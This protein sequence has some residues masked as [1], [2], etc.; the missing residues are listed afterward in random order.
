[1]EFN[2]KRDLALK[3]YKDMDWHYTTK[4]FLP[5]PDT[6]SFFYNYNNNPCPGVEVKQA[7]LLERGEGSI[8]AMY[9]GSKEKKKRLT[10]NQ[11][12]IL[13]RS[14]QEEIK[15]DPEKKMKLS[16]E[17]GLQPRQIAVWFQNRR[18]RWKTKQLE[19]LYDALKHQYDVISNEKQKL[20][21]EVV[22]LKA[23][24]SKEQGF[25]K[26]RLGG[27]PEISGVETVES[28]S[29]GLRGS[30]KAQGKSNIEQVADEG[31]CS[32]SV[33]DY[34]TVSVPFCQWPVVPY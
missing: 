6:L 23:M 3:L 12:E 18:T 33:E 8:P 25:G 4:P 26:Q 22:K 27:Y 34:N 2:G 1:M 9:N 30:N 5:H 28:T 13:E 21:E 15:L 31:F 11:L 17:L 14:F 29:E 10:S 16:R 7:T 32:F 20:Q 24:L 19:H